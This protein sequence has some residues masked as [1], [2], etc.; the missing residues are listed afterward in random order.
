MTNFE[1]RLLNPKPGGPIEAA[2]DFGIDLSLLVER[3][4]LTP[5]ERL[6]DLQSFV[7]ALEEIRGAGKP[8]CDRSS[9]DTT[10]PDQG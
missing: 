1:E 7:R 2:R 3:L 5:E 8:N 4:R 6:R 9:Q 10:T